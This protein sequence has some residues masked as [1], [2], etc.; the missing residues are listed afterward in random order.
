LLE[1]LDLGHVILRNRTLMGSMHTGL[2]ETGKNLFGGVGRLDEMAQFYKARAEGHVGLIVTGGIS[3]NTAGRVYL[4]AAKLTT[5]NESRAH[6]V[7][8]DAVHAANGRIAMQIL[9]AGRYAYQPF[10]VSASAIKSPIGMNTPVALSTSEVYTTIDD[11]VK[12]S[13]FA[14]S[15]GYDGVEIMGSEGYLI[16]QF[17]VKRTN[18]RNDEWGGS[19]ENRMRLA[20]EIVRSVRKAVGKDFIIIYR[21]S[22][23]DLVDDGSSWQEVVELA[24]K[25]EDAGA[26]IINTGIGEI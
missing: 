4:G 6:Q 23:L 22:M 5:A 12:C 26:T 15:A 20:V 18:T 2:E 19:Y 24:K 16:N 17:L 11:F 3:P 8:T 25:I 9:H 1:P 21:L 13:E 14:K 10:P 7:V